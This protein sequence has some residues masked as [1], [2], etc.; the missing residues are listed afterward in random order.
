MIVTEQ[1]GLRW[2]ATKTDSAPGQTSA[3]SF[4]FP[5]YC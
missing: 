4:E 1:E 2:P 5:N 3:Y